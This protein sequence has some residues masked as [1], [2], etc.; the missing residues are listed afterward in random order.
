MNIM[1]DY[2]FTLNEFEQTLNCISRWFS[3]RDRCDR[4]IAVCI[5][6]NTR[7]EDK[8][9]LHRKCFSRE[10]LIKLFYIT[11]L[12]A[13]LFMVLPLQDD[14]LKKSFAAL[15]KV[16]CPTLVSTRWG[17]LCL[18][19]KQYFCFRFEARLVMYFFQRK[20]KTSQRSS[21]GNQ[22]HESGS[23]CLTG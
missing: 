1:Q 23:K 12:V 21:K 6:Q 4:F 3:I 15:F 9:A 13:G 20:R 22:H 18:H 11:C 14:R 8:R 16:T 10:H 7:I 2:F 5:N 17:Y 19:W